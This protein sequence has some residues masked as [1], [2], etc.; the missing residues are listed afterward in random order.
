MSQ[1]SRFSMGA[2]GG[3]YVATETGNTGGAVSP[4]GANNLNVVGDAIFTYVTGTPGTNT[5]LVQLNNK[6]Q[7]NTQ[8]VDATPTVSFSIAMVAN[9][10]ISVFIELV[11]AYSDYS[12]ALSSTKFAIATKVGAAA[13]VISSTNGSVAKTNG[14]PVTAGLTFD[15]NG[16]NIRC[17]VTGVAA[18]TINWKIDIYYLVQNA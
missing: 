5:L 17:I 7:I 6:Q 14:I 4:D 2:I 9:E 13:P 15:I 3:P 11:A 18:T 8:T 12:E 1:I 10:A 16:N